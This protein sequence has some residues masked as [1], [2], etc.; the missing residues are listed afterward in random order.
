MEKTE[1]FMKNLVVKIVDK[2]PYALTVEYK[3]VT[4]NERGRRLKESDSYFE[5]YEFREVT[6]EELLKLRLSGTPGIAYKFDESLYYTEVPGDLK[7][8]RVDDSNGVH[9]CG[10]NCTKVCAGCTR[11]RDLTVAFQLRMNKEFPY[12]V[13]DSWRIEKYD[14]VQEALE[15]FNMYQQNDGCTVYRCANYEEAPPRVSKRVSTTDLKVLLASMYWDDFSG[16][17]R[18][19]RSRINA[20]KTS[21]Y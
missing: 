10:K 9:L 6:A 11:V 1:V 12:T 14:Y 2:K 21:D 17:L 16:D 18:E 3:D 19:M 5:E 8:N 13:L 4:Y 15:A 20:N 7:I